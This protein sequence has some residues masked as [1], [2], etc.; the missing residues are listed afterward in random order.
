MFLSISR[1]ELTLQG[2]KVSPEQRGDLIFLHVI[3][4]KF[5]DRLARKWEEMK[6]RKK[7]ITHPL[8][9]TAVLDDLKKILREEILVRTKL[10]EK[11]G[12]DFKRHSG[13]ERQKD[14]KSHQNK[15]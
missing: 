2:L 9:T 15:S 7:D 1:A 6:I 5:Y 3:E 10:D 13:Q 12:Q 14:E 11:K 8:G 4:T